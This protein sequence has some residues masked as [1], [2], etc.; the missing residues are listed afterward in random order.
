M[1]SY[2]YIRH[3]RLQWLTF[4]GAQ[5]AVTA[6]PAGRGVQTGLRTQIVAAD[7]Q[8]VRACERQ[9]CA[10]RPEPLF[11]KNPVFGRRQKW[12]RRQIRYP[13][14]MPFRRRPGGA[15]VSAFAA[16][17]TLRKRRA[18]SRFRPLPSTPKGTVAT[19]RKNICYRG[20]ALLSIE[21]QAG[22]ALV[23]AV[24]CRA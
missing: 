11:V 18:Q 15:A 14:G 22:A 10:L 13:T 4:I 1:L 20:L 7:T 8:P 9:K 12:R 19:C 16:P 17:A 24:S 3:F 21:N 23:T 6:S 2:G 5:L